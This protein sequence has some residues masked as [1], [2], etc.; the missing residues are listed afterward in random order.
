MASLWL[1][2]PL[3]LTPPPAGKRKIGRSKPLID[4]AGLQKSVFDGELCDD[5]VWLATQGCEKDL[6][7][8][9]WSIQ[10]LLKCLQFL[11]PFQPQGR[12]DFKESEW[13]QARNGEWFPCDVYRIPY[14]D[15]RRCRAPNGL[16]FY[17]KFSINEDESLMLVM[18]RTHLSR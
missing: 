16:E 17:L 14:D 15:Q 7:N 5:D 13:C 18:I 1:L 10:D 2:D 9:G 6:Q 12:H 8:L 11:K 4:L 3:S